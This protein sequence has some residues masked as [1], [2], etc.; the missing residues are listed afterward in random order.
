VG[1]LELSCAAESGHIVIRIKEDGKGLDYARVRSRAKELFPA[2]AGDID[3][4]EESALNSYLFMSGFSTKDAISDLSGRG[5]GLDIVRHNI[6]KIK[7]KITLTSV[8]GQ[9]TE[10]VLALPLSLATVDGFFVGS[11]GEKFLVPANFVKEVII[12]KA[13]DVMD[14]LNRRAFVLRN[15]VVPMYPLSVLLGKDEDDPFDRQKFYIVVV[16]AFGEIMGIM[17][18]SIIQ[19][20]TLIYK[21][22]PANLAGIKAIQGIVFDENFDI[23]NILYVPELMNQCKRIRSIDTRRRYSSARRET[24]RILVVDDSHTTREI[25]KSILE[26]EQYQVSTAVDGID[27]LE[28]LREQHYHLIVTDINMPRMDGLTF[29]GNLRNIAAYQDIPVIVV[30]SDE[31]PVLRRKFMDSGASSFIVKSEFERGNLVETVK[32]LIG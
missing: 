9:G 18:D 3:T 13:G 21:P 11:S 17:V 25:E 4:M 23:I 8:K 31:D 29:V 14:L 16:E 15:I 24:K 22:V 5:V 32:S 7:G 1:H 12:V 26:L 6:E 28:K 20:T 10:F 27:G 19:Y 2:Q 30:S